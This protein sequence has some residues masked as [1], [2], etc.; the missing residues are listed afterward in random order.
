MNHWLKDLLNFAFP[1]QCHVCGAKLAPHE[2]FACTHCLDSLP[3]TGFHHRDMNPM[4]ER[5]A[6][7]FPFVRAS[8]HFFYTR[9]SAMSVLMQDMKYRHFPDIGNL[10]GEIM[11]REL[12]PTGFFNDI[13]LIVPMPMHKVKQAI[14]GYNQVHHIADGVSTATGIPV[15]QALKAIKP[16]RTQTSLSR[17][18]RL[19]NTTGIFK[20][21]NPSGL[22]GKGVLLID[23]VCTTGA[24]MSSAG[25]LVSKEAPT[26]RISVL[27]LGVT[28]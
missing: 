9:D 5:L 22:H 3:R 12:F 19:N 16:H 25:V 14:R 15:I 6:G 23:D 2:R 21:Q 7:H 4:E 28:F 20:L 24:T 26:A 11:G 10:L 8:G 17:E 13:D 18:Q 27:T 1:K